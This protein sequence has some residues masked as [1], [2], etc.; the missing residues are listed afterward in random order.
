MSVG[1]DRSL[2]PNAQT[3]THVSTS[4]QSHFAAGGKHTLC[5]SCGVYAQRSVPILHAPQAPCAPC[6]PFAKPHA[7]MAPLACQDQMH[8]QAPCKNEMQPQRTSLRVQVCN[9]GRRL[10]A[11]RVPAAVMASIQDT[12]TRLPVH[13]RHIGVG[14]VAARAHRACAH[15]KEEQ[16]GGRRQGF[17]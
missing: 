6:Q 3:K 5:P 10:H 9:A 1:A 14:A 16:R 4:L 7:A 8:T 11:A 15:T 17:C 12:I 13:A 2:C